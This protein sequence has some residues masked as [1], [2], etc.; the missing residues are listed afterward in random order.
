MAMVNAQM[1]LGPGLVGLS[2]F[3]GEQG[4]TYGYMAPEVLRFAPPTPALDIYSFGVT[5]HEVLTAETSHDRCREL[6]CTRPP[7]GMTLPDS[8]MFILRPVLS[9]VGMKVRLPSGCSC[10][11]TPCTPPR[12]KLN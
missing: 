8:S 4:G 1:C 10:S 2:V 5:V 11:T 12:I 7:F 6:R 3:L 9:P